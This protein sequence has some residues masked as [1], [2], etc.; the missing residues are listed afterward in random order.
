MFDYVDLLY[1]SVDLTL[2]NVLY[3]S[4]ERFLE[5]RAIIQRM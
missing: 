5:Y 4:V 3:I 1:I 2:H